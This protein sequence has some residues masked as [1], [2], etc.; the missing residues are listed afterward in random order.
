MTIL[1]SLEKD[2]QDELGVTGRCPEIVLSMP[3]I[4]RCSSLV[5]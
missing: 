4:F 3:R 2:V 5:P 1:K